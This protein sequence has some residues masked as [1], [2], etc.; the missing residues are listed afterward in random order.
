MIRSMTGFGTV[1]HA[2]NGVSFVVE[3]RGGN[4]R[5]LKVV[6][7]L[8]ERFQFAENAVEKAVR[9]RLS[10]GSISIAV[11]VQ[12][13][14][15]EALSPIDGP[16]L[17]RYIDD[18]AKARLPEGVQ[19]TI[20]LGA[21]AALPG[22]IHSPDFDDDERQRLTKLLEDL[23][24]RSIDAM[25]I[26]RCEEGQAL[27][28]ALMDCVNGLRGHVDVVTERS[29]EVAKEYH[30]RL[31]SRVSALMQGGGFE[32]EADALA[33][34]VALFAERCDITEELTRLQ[35]H[36]HQFVELCEREEPTGRTLDFLSQELLREA[37]TIGSKSNDATIARHVVEMKTLIDRIKEQVQNV[38]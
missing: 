7:K 6:I 30:A 1:E 35:S 3:A 9:A 23:A 2:E 16:A 33:R 4:H 11:R 22:V 15:D 28:E 26:M 17:Q 38:E 19:A 36:L 24:V 20:D 8:P 29:P 10:R 32:L 5:Y 25:T 14:S 12:G 27:H 13:G 34:E 21:I 31:E 18:L 37:N